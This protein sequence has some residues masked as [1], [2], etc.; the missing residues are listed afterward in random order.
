MLVDSQELTERITT[1]QKTSET[2][3]LLTRSPSVVSIVQANL[4][5][6]AN[7]W[8]FLRV[9]LLAVLGLTVLSASQSLTLGALLLLGVVVGM[10][11]RRRLL[12]H[13][14]RPLADASLTA[15]LR[16]ALL[17]C[18][19]RS[20]P[21]LVPS[22]LCAAYLTWQYAS[23]TAL[24]V[25]TQLS[26]GVTTF[27]SLT[28]VIRTLL[29]PCPPAEPFLLLPMALATP[30]SRRLRVLV[31]LLIASVIGPVIVTNAELPISLVLLTGDAFVLLLVVNLLWI[32][33]LLGQLP[34]FSQ[35]LRSRLVLG[36]GL[37]TGLGAAWVGYPH[38]A[39]FI[40][41]GII[42]T[43]VALSLSW[44][45]ARL[46][47][48]LYDTVDTGQQPWAS[49]LRSR[50]GVKSGE[51]MPGLVWLRVLTALMLWSG[52]ILFIL[53]IWNLVPANSTEILAY[54]TQPFTIGAVHFAPVRLPLALLSFFV[55]TSLSS[56]L[57]RRLEQQWLRRAH[58]DRGARE[59]VVTIS[60]YVGL[61][62]AALLT[63]SV[64][65]IGLE[66]LAL[67]AGAL[68]LGIG[69]GLQNIVNNFVSGI[70]LLFERPIK[71]G[72]WV[73]VGTTQGHVR[74]ISIRSTRIQ[75]FDYTDVIVPNSRLIAEEVT[76]WTL[77]DNIGRLRLPVGVAYGSD[78]VRVKQVLLELAN[79]HQSV[80]KKHPLIPPPKA[81]FVGFGESALNFELWCFIH[82]INYKWDVI[83]QS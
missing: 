2:A 55:V 24:V 22:V 13:A 64:L 78:T 41:R 76:N 42:M 6:P 52:C 11:G 61:L 54:F 21:L 47:T 80:V 46:C 14:Q 25:I 60:G 35:T 50:L 59:A 16:R 63:L 56:W 32:V 48:E 82:D 79:A 51:P 62:V 26:Y 20:L 66:N 7:V 77:Q 44:L 37:L 40:I 12:Q 58:L 71:T 1:L 39:T 28:T 18:G 31:L 4:D 68:S 15:G 10:S 57:K 23:S 38:L 36:L 67:V 65:G 8:L 81:L 45:V 17:A 34:V 53:I 70:I 5:N 73:Q 69:F 43:V 49:R 30:L 74:K 3:Y 29:T 9:N 72:D 83:T 27:V 75:T 33:A 19:G